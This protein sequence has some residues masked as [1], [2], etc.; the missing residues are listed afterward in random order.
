MNTI[1]TISIKDQ[2]I[3]KYIGIP[4]LSIKAK[5]ENLELKLFASFGEIDE[6]KWMTNF[7]KLNELKSLDF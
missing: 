6:K 4:E 3:E 7:K 1:K 5:I 2:I